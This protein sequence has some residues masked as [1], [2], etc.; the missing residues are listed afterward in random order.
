MPKTPILTSRYS[1]T[2]SMCLH[3]RPVLSSSVPEASV[4]DNRNLTM[5]PVTVHQLLAHA[6]PSEDG[7][8]YLDDVR[9]HNVR[10][11]PEGVHIDAMISEFSNETKETIM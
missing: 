5:S 7:Y 8:F 2:T 3:Y 1:S 11:R 4:M 10:N 6:E 9:L